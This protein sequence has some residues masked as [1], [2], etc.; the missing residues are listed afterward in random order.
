MFFYFLMTINSLFK[1]LKK[2]EISL[3]NLIIIAAQIHLIS[4]SFLNIGSV[5]YV[6]PVYSI[7]T[8]STLVY[9]KNFL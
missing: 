1:I 6:M 9:F 5:R 8:L 7:I 4:V 3:I 2:R